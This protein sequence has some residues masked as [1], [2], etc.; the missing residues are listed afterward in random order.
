MEEVRLLKRNVN[1]R[2]IPER[3]EPARAYGTSSSTRSAQ[4]SHV[5]DIDDWPRGTGEQN[6][7]PAAYF[8][9]VLNLSIY[10]LQKMSETC[11]VPKHI[12]LTYLHF[13]RKG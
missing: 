11:G 10:P 4:R 5:E 6:E 2:L 12:V 7:S 9:T 13:F 1:R 3:V 8:N